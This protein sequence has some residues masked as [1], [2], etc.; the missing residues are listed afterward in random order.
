MEKIK[1]TSDDWA[2]LLPES[3]FT[4]GNTK[5]NTRP[6]SIRETTKLIR[7]F[8][9]VRGY[10]AEKEITAENYQDPNNISIVLEIIMDSSPDIISDCSGLDLE[11]VMSLP[12]HIAADLLR[13]LIEL[14]L[15]SK[16]DLEKNLQSLAVEIKKIQEISGK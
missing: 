7:L 3:E 12:I 6:L 4:I 11:D 15:N 8:N 2:A 1:L 16:S 14:N 10:L 13:H 9:G 5:L